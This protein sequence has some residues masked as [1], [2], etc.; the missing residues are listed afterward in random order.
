M[1]IRAYRVEYHGKQR[2]VT[3]VVEFPSLLQGRKFLQE[4]SDAGT[5]GVFL[6]YVPADLSGVTPDR[7]SVSHVSVSTITSFGRRRSLSR[8]PGGAL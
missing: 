8:A 5:A 3:L 7:A 2:R 1:G 6:G 4:Q